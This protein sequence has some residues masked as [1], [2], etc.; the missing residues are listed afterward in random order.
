MTGG[1]PSGAGQLLVSSGAG[2][3]SW[4]ASP[5][6]TALTLSGALA[7]AT[8]A[9]T[10]A[11]TI[12]GTL[13]LNGAV[14]T[15]SSVDIALGGGKAF[16]AE[17]HAINSNEYIQASAANEIGVYV[18]GN[19]RYKQ[20]ASLATFLTPGVYTT[21]WTA[22][23]DRRLKTDVDDIDDALA[24]IRGLRPVT[25]RP[26][27]AG[28]EMGMADRRT[29]GFIAQDVERVAPD[30]VGE[31]GDYL[32]VDEIGM[33]PYFARALVQLDERLAALEIA[34]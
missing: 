26:S 34:S 16:Q 2:V 17:R 31:S 15:G 14:L 24:V 29:P 10:G 8:G 13:T 18:G 21:S 22:I 27:E 33:S 23:S 20:T 6:I 7:A 32:T 19:A 3:G 1:D 4:S 25:W 5:S 11:V 28:R 9:F 12:A 30:L